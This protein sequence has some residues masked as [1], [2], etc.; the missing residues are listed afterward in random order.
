MIMTLA[1]FAGLDYRLVV[2][3]MV[4]VL[5]CVGFELIAFSLRFGVWIPQIAT[6]G[7]TFL[8]SFFNLF[9]Q[10]PTNPALFLLSMITFT[11][12][13]LDLFVE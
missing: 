12:L 8:T 3:N 11:G 2:L 6:A 9:Q 4:I 13:A 5:G 1:M 10:W 7:L